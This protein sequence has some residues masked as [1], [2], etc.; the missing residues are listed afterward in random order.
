MICSREI[1]EE[2]VVSIKTGNVYERRLIEKFIDA[3]G[4]EPT[5]GEPLSLKDLVALKTSKVVK[6]RM[7]TTTSIPGMLQMFQ[8]EWDALML[9]TYTLKQQYESV[10]QELAH[11]L[12]QYDASCRVISRL[13]KERDT[14]RNALANARIR[15][16]DNSQSDEMDVD[17]GLSA[18]IQEKIQANAKQKNKKTSKIADL[19]TIENIQS[20]TTLTST[21]P[22]KT[23]QGLL[24]VDHH[25]SK[26][27][28]VTGGADAQAVV[29]DIDSSSVVA[30]FKGHSKTVNKVLFHPTED[31]AFSCSADRTVRSW[32]ASGE[33]TAIH[34]I[35]RHTDNVTSISLHPL[36]SYLASASTD[37][38][39]HMHD[40]QTGATILSATS[41]ASTY[42]AAQ[43]HPDGLILGLGTGDKKAQIW[44]ISRKQNI[45]TLE[46]HER[47]VNGLAF[48]ENGFYL[49]TCDS[50]SVKIWDLRK[51]QLC[52]E[53]IETK[54][55]VHNIQWDK[56]GTYLAIAGESLTI[57]NL[58]GKNSFVH[59]KDITDGSQ[60]TDAKWSNN[61][62]YLVSTSMDSSLKMWGNQ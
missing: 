8:N 60:F 49:A 20:F 31:M 58:K 6:P 2:P 54:G 22:H 12:Y 25:P 27:L 56:S 16:N 39:W 34:T 21:N 36:G 32:R 62:Q 29:Y 1:P 35:K 18:E 47:P 38:T 13:I 42:E 37:R 59:T 23:A 55:H 14:A 46:G 45:V 19:A 61:S 26:Q 28:V 5:T 50:S 33:A 3:N 51:E 10:R 48:S 44:D 15:S 40:V 17:A 11:S 53:T 7:S 57:Y 24:S 43:F 52:L 30:T 41:G 4:K 9:E